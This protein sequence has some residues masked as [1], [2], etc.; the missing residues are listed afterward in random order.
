MTIFY[1]NIGSDD[2]RFPKVTF[3]TLPAASEATAPAPLQL[4]AI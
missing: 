4:P 1:L 3:A 2:D